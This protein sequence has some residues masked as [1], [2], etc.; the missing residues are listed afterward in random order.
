MRLLF[1]G[2]IT[3]LFDYN[4]TLLFDSNIR[5]NTYTIQYII[6]WLNRL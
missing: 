4:I 1:D 3:L 2:D 6:Y 5:N